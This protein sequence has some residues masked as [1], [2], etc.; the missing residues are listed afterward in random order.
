MRSVVAEVGRIDLLVHSAGMLAGTWVRKE[1]LEGFDSLLTANLRSAFVTT[2]AALQTMEAGGRIVFLSSS[3]AHQP[4]PARAAYSASKAGLNAF[5]G[6]LAKEVERDGIAVHVVT[7][8]PVD[9]PML[10]DVRFP[11]FAMSVDDVARAIVWLDTLAPG[12]VLPELV[13]RA[14]ETGPF[15]AQQV[16]PPA[17][18]DLG[19]G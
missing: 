3:S 19:R 6:A 5:A 15:A 8:A 11:M 12:V 4:Q 9:T 17:A 7:P 10:D 16:I 14:A 1:S 2:N 18:K 13:L